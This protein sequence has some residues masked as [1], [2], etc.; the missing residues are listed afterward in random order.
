MSLSQGGYT[1]PATLAR[2]PLSVTPMVSL[3][4]SALTTKYRLNEQLVALGDDYYVQTDAG[5]RAFK[6]DGSAIRTHDTLRFET[7]DGNVLCEFRPRLAG[8]RG[9]ISIA[10]LNGEHVVTVRRNRTTPHRDLFTIQHNRE[11]PFVTMGDVGI[12]EYEICS[13]T[14]SVAVVSKRWF[15]ARGSYGIEV[16]HQEIGVF[17]L[18]AVVAIDQMLSTHVL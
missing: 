5:Q 2:D 8:L 1:K 7:L 18:A 12:H 16:A 10:D 3:M 11:L 17:L 13:P 4:N 9:A 15:R 6:I 14:A